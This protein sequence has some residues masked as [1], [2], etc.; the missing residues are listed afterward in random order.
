MGDKGATTV[1]LAAVTEDELRETLE[2]AWE[3]HQ[4]MEYPAMG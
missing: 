2:R 1:V 4:W 3:L